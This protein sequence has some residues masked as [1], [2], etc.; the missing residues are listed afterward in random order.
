MTSAETADQAEHWRSR[1]RRLVLVDGVF[2][3]LMDTVTGGVFLAGLALYLG[4]NN[5]T[6]GLIAAL[7]FLAQ[8]AQLPAVRS[9]VGEPNR[10][11]VVVIASGL[12]RSFLFVIALLVFLQADRLSPLILIV[13]LGAMSALTV[14]STAAWN[15]WMRDVIER[16]QLGRYF[17]RRLRLT[18]LFSASALLLAGWLLDR[19]EGAG[20][21]STGYAILFTVGGACGLIS[22]WFLSRIP[23]PT[24]IRA[25][26]HRNAW[27]LLREP[28]TLAKNRRMVAA[29]SLVAAMLTLALPFT[30]VFMLRSLRLS[31]LVVTALALLSS[32][33]YVGGLRAWG[34]LSD[35]FGNRPVLQISVGM[36]LVA[37]AGWGIV[38]SQGPWLLV[39]LLGFLHFLSG[40]AIGGV[41]LTATNILLK[42]APE[43]G[44]PAYLAAMSL[45]RALVAGLATLAAGLLWQLVGSGTLFTVDAVVAA[46]AFKGFHL[47][48]LLSV[49]T[50][51]V[52]LVALRGIEEEGGVPVVHV[53]RAMRRE[54]RMLS[55]VAGI[56]AFV[57]VVSYVVEFLVYKPPEDENLKRLPTPSAS[58][59]RKPHR[60]L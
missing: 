60:I 12:A 9:L 11:R 33:A 51:L 27:A 44:A 15:W 22:I 49:A 38:G 28:L 4:A 37:L 16:D 29:L 48:A 14:I 55:S 59:G 6:V 45:L 57:H 1:A 30:A 10:K 25:P 8:V 53:A 40:F 5:F 7:P 52:A 41:D 54:V 46:W 21:P 3:R 34:H 2:S 56:R 23:H 31:F 50:G 17:G 32:L 36:L 19:Y 35:R 18:M 42:T 39:A 20:D 47:L 43:A 24:P 13:L 58:A 26:A